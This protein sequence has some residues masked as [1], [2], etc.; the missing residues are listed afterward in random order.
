VAVTT[1][2]DLVKLRLTRLGERPL[3][4]LQVRLHVE[5]GREALDRRLE[6]AVRHE[7]ETQA[8]ARAGDQG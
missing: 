6:E 5:A 3:W 4:A 7:P 2:K 1:Q 8:R